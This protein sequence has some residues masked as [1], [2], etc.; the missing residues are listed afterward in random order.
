[1]KKKKI[2][3]ILISIFIL[4][5]GLVSFSSYKFKENK[6]ITSYIAYYYDG[7]NHNNPPSKEDYVIEETKCDK[8]TGSWSNSK[9]QLNLSNIEGKFGCSLKFRRKILAYKLIVN[10][11]GGTYDGSTGK[12]E[13]NIEIGKTREIEDA[14]RKG[15]TFTGWTLT[16][17]TSTFEDNVFTMGYEDST[18]TA[19]YTINKYKITISGTNECDGEYEAEYNSSIDLC[20]PTKEDYTFTGWN[21]ENA[22]VEGNKL[23]VS[24]S[25][26]TISPKW[27]ETKYDY[28][29]NHSK[30]NL[31]GTTYT[32][33]EKTTG[34]ATKETII[35]AQLKN[36]PGFTAPKAQSMVIDKDISKNIINYNY[37]RNKYTLDVDANGGTYT[38]QTNFEL[39]F[40]QEIT[41]ANPT[42][43]GFNFAGW[44]AT[45]GTVNDS[46]YTMGAN[47]A[48]LTAKWSAKQF[49]VSFDANEGNVATPSKEV[50]FG[51]TYGELPT[52]TR[53]GYTFD[54]WF[55]SATGGTKKVSSTIV[56]LTANETLY[57]HWS[58]NKYNVSFNAN[59]GTSS[60]ESKQVT[61]AEKYGELPTPTKLGY[62]FS[63]WYT[64]ITKGS[65]KTA[66]TVVYITANETLYAHWDAKKYTITFN[67]NGGSAV[68]SKEVTYGE[69]YG[70]L[71]TPVKEG[72]Q[73]LGWYL[74][75]DLT[76]GVN[77][78]STVLDEV[79]TLYAKW[80]IGSYKLS[81]NPNGGTYSSSTGIQEFSLNWKETFNLDSITRTGY[82][83]DKWEI[84]GKNT[85]INS[86]VLT[87]GVENSTIKALWNINSY[88]LTIQDSYTC[89]GTTSLN[90][91]ATYELCE[92]TREGYTFTGWD[93]T[94]G[95]VTNK[96]FKM[97]AANA[98]LTAKWQPN[99][100]TYIVYHNKLNTDGTTYTLVDGDTYKDEALFDSEVTPETKT[101]V[102][103]TSPQSKTIKIVV[104]E[105]DPPTKNKVDYNYERNKSILTIDL[106]GGTING[107]TTR[108]LYYEEESEIET[109]TR[110]GYNFTGWTKTSGTLTDNIFKMGLEAATLTANY[111]VR[112]FR[113]T[114]NAN[115]GGL[116]TEGINVTYDEKYGELPTP[117]REGYTF[118]GWY[119]QL[120][121]GEKITSESTV[122]VTD[123]STL[124]A[125]WSINTYHLT[126]YTTSDSP[127][128]M[129]VEYGLKIRDITN[130]VKEG[131]R[132]L[133]WYYD[134]SFNSGVSENL[135]INEDM[136]LYAKF[137]EGSF[138]LTINPNGGTY[139]GVS[140]NT[141]TYLTYNEEIE[142]QAIERIG[143]SF[144]KW[145]IT[146]NNTTINS[147]KL[148]MGSEDSTIK[149]LWNINSYNLTILNSYTCDTTVNL[150]YNDSYDLCTPTRE[151]YVFTG[152][153]ETSGTLS[154]STFIIG[155]SDAILTASWKEDNYAYIVYHSKMNMDG[156]SY[157]LIDADTYIGEAKFNSQV[158][159]EPNTYTGFTSPQSKTITI[160][161][162]ENNPPTTN[163]VDYK[164]TRNKHTLTLDLNGGEYSGDTSKELYYDEEC[165][166]LTPSKEGYNFDGWNSSYGLKTDSI[167]KMGDSNVTLTAVYS[168]K[169]YTIY[170]NADGGSINIE[171]KQVGYNSTYGDLPTPNKEGYIFEGWYTNL[172][173]G[174]K[175]TSGS[176]FTLQT[177][178]TLYAHYTERTYTVYFDGNMG[179]PSISSKEVTYNFPYGTL[180]S[181]TRDGYEFAGWYTL[182]NDGE[183]VTA[184]SIVDTAKNHTLY[185]HWDAKNIKVTFDAN[186]GSVDTEYK[187][188]A[189]NHEY[190]LLPEAS[191][192]GFAFAGWFT[193]ANGGTRV[194]ST[195]NV[196]VTSDIT[197]YAH[198]AGNTYYVQ[199]NANGGLGTM[200]NQTLTYGIPMNLR[201]NAFTREGY[202][203]AGWATSPTGSVVYED[204]A[205]VNNLSLIENDEYPLYA[206]WTPVVSFTSY[207]RGLSESTTVIQDDGTND[208]NMRFTGTNPNNYVK[209]KLSDGTYEAW[210]VIGVF[211]SNSHG[212]VSDRVKIMKSDISENKLAYDNNNVND[213]SVSSLKTTLN[214][215]DY[216]Y[217]GSNLIEDA[218]WK[219]GGHSTLDGVLTSEWYT[220]ERG[221]EVYD[222][223]ATEWTG[224]IALAYPS[225]IGYSIEN[226]VNR[227]KC[228]AKDMYHWENDGYFNVCFTSS[229]MFSNSNSW[230]TLTPDS[231]RAD[232]SYFIDN[233]QYLYYGDTNIRDNFIPAAYL[234][235]N[236]VCTNCEDADA[237]SESNPFELQ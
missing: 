59:G 213:W 203:F 26:A 36:Y 88:T 16:G 187:M 18:L 186:T 62:N 222:G 237:G 6:E 91:N 48:T 163:K 171:S 31:D 215:E 83:F 98:T 24:D 169:K 52:P 147:N 35:N 75:S 73:F 78:D 105:D 155:A 9:W 201:G 92:P 142:L 116:T 58:A 128:E 209:F 118:D 106:N 111:E 1:M 167:F 164:Y 158:T 94:S 166:L 100:Y 139:G 96:I 152:W 176:I 225:D 217:A 49:I 103:F 87:M 14:T 227:S 140:S 27:V 50:Y 138:L 208:H 130:P 61:Y 229:W 193:E 178:Q 180:A 197:L 133:G 33:F 212:S 76:T 77:S 107:P 156:S 101:Y 129:D 191:K 8:A 220:Y 134:N 154:G 157:T 5:I 123:N 198:W 46:K 93:Y 99:S 218:T 89:D 207:L 32:L 3:I 29:I 21:V 37:T 113:I 146:G 189:H 82:T 181:A 200:L 34:S 202:A 109:P 121:D 117:T 12:Q 141:N 54:G 4:I 162:E 90:Y 206:V 66:D 39:Y 51:K 131:Y 17:D 45:S 234:K 84:T 175:I 224:K 174:D 11:N 44:Q 232:N 38:G 190:G 135:V 25:D 85:V 47:N 2:T 72:Y 160:A 235:S 119:T 177:N 136:T 145:E 104:D 125:H 228:L 149:A 110:D 172:D 81:I 65:Q 28:V 67:S 184:E 182:A 230:L 13:Y 132:F 53:T 68:S 102:G 216:K 114:F 30:Q 211:N 168:E 210:R 194:L 40:E 137:G 80:G 43:D 64:H 41:L 122:K 126:L 231:S 71:P 70:E 60:I 19:N 79:T 57:A 204:G 219:L 205:E 97:G 63:G 233:R 159:P 86:N 95:N 179:T 42:L 143:Y 199:F 214:G 165:E 108:I 112:H 69:K 20:V 7:E 56:D 221:T 153:V 170:F 23:I 10:P 151:G 173:G 188:V 15:Y 223:H 124:Y 236:I 74:N 150:N 185:A 183:K 55:T 120:E 22:K 144:D 195:S 115:G 148:T 196:S 161:I 127:I 226:G 192:S